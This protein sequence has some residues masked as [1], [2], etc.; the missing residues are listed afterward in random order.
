MLD[1][2]VA[3][4][5]TIIGDIHGKASALES[6]LRERSVEAELAAGTHTLIFVGDIVD[7]GPTEE[8]DG[9]RVHTGVERLL[10]RAIDLRRRFPKQV[11]SIAGN[12]EI[13]HAQD[14]QQRGLVAGQVSAWGKQGRLTLTSE[15][16]EFLQRLPVALR[17]QVGGTRAIVVHGGVPERAMSLHD[18]PRDASCLADLHADRTVRNLLWTN[19]S[20]SLGGGG[21]FSFSY[22]RLHVAAFLQANEAQVLI[23]GHRNEPEVR[24]LPGGLRFICVHT[25]QGDEARDVAADGYVY[26]TW[27]SPA[28]PALIRRDPVRERSQ[29]ASSS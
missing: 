1:F 7:R 6:I 19:P 22:T 2:P 14:I 26:L 15:R 10:D 18:L 13:M 12:H 11:V 9:E 25:A 16:I 20:W 4:R 5:L 28:A 24:E 21:S 17:I 23:R 3:R 8:R 29:G 27:D